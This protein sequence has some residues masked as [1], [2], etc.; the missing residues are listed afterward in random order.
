[1]ADSFVYIYIIHN[2]RLGTGQPRIAAYI[3]I[4]TF[5]YNPQCKFVYINNKAP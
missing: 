3:P 5:I 4:T 1:M 2:I